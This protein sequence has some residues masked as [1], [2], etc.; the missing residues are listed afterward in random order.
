[1]AGHES[2]DGKVRYA[3][4]GA[5][6]FGQAAVLPAFAHSTENSRLA[7]I[8]SG[9]AEKR[10]AL[11]AKY[12][13]PAVPYEKSDEL[14]ASGSID[15]VYIV[16]PNSEHRDHTLAAARHGVHVLCEK[17]LADTAAA[18]EE[19]IAACDRGN[20][21]LMTAYRLH[22]EKAN[23][24]AV[25]M[26]RD[27]TIGDP[28]L[29]HAVNTQTVDDGN[30]RL[31]PQLGGGPLLDVGIYCVNAARYLFRADPTEVTGFAATAAADDPRFKGVPEM[32]SAILRFPGDRLASISCGF[33]EAKV[34]ACQLI[35][36]KGDVRLDPGFPFVGERKL[37]LTVG[38]KTSEKTF[39]PQDQVAPEIVYFSNCIL[40]GGRPEPDGYEGLIDLRVMEAIHHSAMKGVA[41]PLQP[42]GRKPRPDLRQQINKPAVKEPELVNAAPPGGG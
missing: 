11:A 27:G 10:D 1:M 30:I 31:K 12:G 13:V 14:L 2:P 41:V 22:F 40:T 34:S 24:T 9:D 16:T 4:V 38:G 37:Y 8:V 21:L 35:G 39:P 3:V 25:E 23:L 7:A 32:V 26:G 42:V 36:T 17:P 18:A 20:V 5:G 6:W 29:I 15:A 19:M 28:R 33:A